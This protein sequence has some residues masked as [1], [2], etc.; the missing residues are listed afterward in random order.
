MRK[1]IEILLLLLMVCQS[2]YIYPAT[3]VV[4]DVQHGEVY[5]ETP[6]GTK[7]HMYQEENWRIGDEA[8]CIMFTRGTKERSDDVI[9]QIRY[10]GW[11]YEP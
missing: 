4:T 9:L 7:Y 2:H 6:A 3:M 5:L 1:I 10:T 8:A 11:K